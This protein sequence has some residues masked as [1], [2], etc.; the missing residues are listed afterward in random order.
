MTIEDPLLFV[1]PFVALFLIAVFV[2]TVR[3]NNSKN[4]VKSTLAL[5]LL[6]KHDDSMTATDLTRKIFPRF[7]EHDD[8]TST[9]LEGQVKHVDMST[10]ISSSSSS[11]VK[12]IELQGGLC[13]GIGI[14]LE[15][16]LTREE[17]L[18][19]I[20]KT[21]EM[22]YGRLGKGK[23]G[24]AYRGNR[25]IQVEDK[26]GV[27]TEVLWKKIEP[28]I[29]HLCAQDIGIPDEIGE[30]RCDGLNRRF[31]FAKYSKG[32][33]FAVHKD[34]PTVYEQEECSFYTVNIYLNDLQTDQGGTT[35][36]FEKMQSKKEICSAGGVAG[37]MVIFKQSQFPNSAPHDGEL[38]KYGVKYLMRTDVIFKRGCECETRDNL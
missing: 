32:E 25:R 17:C 26:T 30:W 33:G 24:Q 8:G 19:I 21:E 7:Q 9:H 15:N 10:W 35:R 16:V 36:F 29:A 12:V 6:E 28:Y 37:S 34:K 20:E 27:F 14:I 2:Q 4:N 22:K 13:N 1:S 18:T 3:S 23:T 38:L 5:P 11:N 31:R